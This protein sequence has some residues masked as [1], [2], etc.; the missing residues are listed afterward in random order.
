MGN[1]INIK[2]LALDIE[3]AM[4]R[5]KLDIKDDWF[6]DPLKYDDILNIENILNKINNKLI[7]NAQGENIGYKAGFALHIDIPK[8]GFTSRYSTEIDII[9]RVFCQA[10]IDFIAED[11][12]AL[13][14]NRI[15]SH[16]LNKERTDEKYFFRYPVEEWKKF[17]NDTALE[18]GADNNVLLLT[19]LTNL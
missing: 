12:D 13:H 9:D 8:P 3:K 10:L 16:R 1:I 11:L 18:L 15:Y 17:I 6:Q 4:K 14:S 7:K 2:G 19:D 5:T